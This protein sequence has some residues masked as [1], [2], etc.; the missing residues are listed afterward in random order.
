MFLCN[1]IH[2]QCPAVSV[3]YLVE[4]PLYWQHCRVNAAHFAHFTVVKSFRKFAR[5][6]QYSYSALYEMEKGMPSVLGIID[7]PTRAE[8]PKLWNSTHTLTHLVCNGHLI[9]NFLSF[10]MSLAVVMNCGA[11]NALHGFEIR[12]FSFFSKTLFYTQIQRYTAA[13][14]TTCYITI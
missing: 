12:M 3:S 7:E 10:H 11:G 2:Y 5:A 9:A 14:G 8:K 6:R 1:P 13:A 4:A